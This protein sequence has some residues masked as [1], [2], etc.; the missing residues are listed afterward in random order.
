MAFR[1]TPGTP[2]PFNIPAG[3]DV[4]RLG[5]DRT[6]RESYQCQFTR[7]P[8]QL[9]DWKEI[10]TGRIRI[11]HANPRFLGRARDT[12]GHNRTH[13]RDSHVISR[14]FPG[15]LRAQPNYTC[16]CTSA[17]CESA[18]LLGNATQLAAHRTPPRQCQP[19]RQ[20]RQPL[21]IYPQSATSTTSPS[22]WT[23]SLLECS[24]Q[25]HSLLPEH[26]HDK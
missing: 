17:G 21:A 4:T 16:T 3:S 6:V 25:T 18:T 11:S 19:P 13:F 1:G 22:G 15:M 8:G 9:G 7:K 23:Q 24:L 26:H 12:P 2:R 20:T 5:L 10:G 14:L